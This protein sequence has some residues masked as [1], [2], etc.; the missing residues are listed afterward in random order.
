M[1]AV[2]CNRKAVL[3]A[4]IVLPSM[5]DTAAEEIPGAGR[6]P[7]PAGR[8]QFSACA[9]ETAKSEAVRAK[10]VITLSPRAYRF[11]FAGA[12]PRRSPVSRAPVRV[13]KNIRPPLYCT[14]LGRLFAPVRPQY[15][16][17]SRDGKA[18]KVR[19]A[20]NSVLFQAVC[21]F[22]NKGV[23]SI[24]PNPPSTIWCGLKG[25]CIRELK[26]CLP[27][28]GRLSSEREVAPH[29]RGDGIRG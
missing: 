14:I 21:R 24:Y 26:R 3:A 20:V 11:A 16:S 10:P 22:S 23:N 18:R 6:L 17:L 5:L 1:K 25:N 13:P 19:K 7:E 9:A 8:A 15:K 28:A 29:G 2:L 4:A 12:L 27:T